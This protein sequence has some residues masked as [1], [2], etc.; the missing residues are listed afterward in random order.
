MEISHKQETEFTYTHQIVSQSVKVGSLLLPT[1]GPIKNSD[2]RHHAYTGIHCL[3][4]IISNIVF[5]TI[6]FF[7]LKFQ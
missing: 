6:M 1:P 5:L 3:D 4:H 7:S 2:D